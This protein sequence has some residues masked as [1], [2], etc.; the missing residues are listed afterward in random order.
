MLRPRVAVT[1]LLVAL[2]AA[3]VV[4]YDDRSDGMHDMEASLDRVVRSQLNAQVRE[5]CVSDPTWFLTGPAHWT[6][7][8]R[9]LHR[10]ESRRAGPS[11]EFSPQPFELF[12]YDEEFLG[13]SGAAHRFP[14]EFRRAMRAS[15]DA[16]IAPHITAEG[17]GR[18]DGDRDRLEGHALRVLRR[19]NG[20][21]RHISPAIACCSRSVLSPCASSWPSLR[22]RRLCGACGAW[23]P[24][25]G[26]RQ[27]W[28]R[29]DRA[30]YLEGRTEF[31]H[32]HL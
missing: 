18:A 3:L 28:F 19:A 6:P 8:E 32:L 24:K 31:S 30:R 22:R 27:Q 25:G 26:N 9:H 20:S 29:V 1:S 10:S 2:P 21:P 5:R 12:A 14:Q 15:P 4:A 11:A 13:W 17:T 7:A 16:A 23:R